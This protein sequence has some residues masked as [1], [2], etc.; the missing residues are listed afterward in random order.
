[1]TSFVT[2]NSVDWRGPSALERASAQVTR[3]RDGPPCREDRS[4]NPRR[5]NTAVWRARA[6]ITPLPRKQASLSRVLV[7]GWYSHATTNPLRT[8]DPGDLDDG[9]PLWVG[10]V[11]LEPTTRPLSS[12]LLGRAVRLREQLVEVPP[13][14]MG[15]SRPR[16]T[17]RRRRG[18]Q[19]ALTPVNSGLAPRD[20]R[21]REASSEAIAG[22][23]I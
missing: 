7:V 14:S 16:V 23:R 6:L 12:T 21:L 3:S 8:T 10:P 17:W 1:M 13:N 2:R 19:H 15:V 9:G 4:F 20:R 18:P 11:E 5:T 22:H